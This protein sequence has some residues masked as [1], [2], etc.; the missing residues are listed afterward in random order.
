[1]N[2]EV[3]KRVI[4]VLLDNMIINSINVIKEVSNMK[5]VDINLLYKAKDIHMEQLTR[6]EEAKEWLENAT[7]HD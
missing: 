4:S 1:M 6:F 7:I 3:A 5:D 2:E